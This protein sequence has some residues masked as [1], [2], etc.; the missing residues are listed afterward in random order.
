[1]DLDTLDSSNPCPSFAAQSCL[2]G[3]PLTVPRQLL[4]EDASNRRFE[5]LRPRAGMLAERCVDQG[6]VTAAADG[7]SF[8]AEPRQDVVVE[9]NGDAGLAWRRLQDGAPRSP[10]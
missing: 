2:S 9:P 3:C 5:R 4:P 6:L 10:A 8:P 1:M 7:V